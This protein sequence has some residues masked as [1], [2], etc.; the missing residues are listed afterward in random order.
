MADIELTNAAIP[1]AGPDQSPMQSSQ[2][3]SLFTSAPTS[4]TPPPRVVVG[5]MPTNAPNAQVEELQNTALP[6]RAVEQYLWEIKHQPNWRRASDTCAD[7]YD[8]NQLTLELVEKLKDRGQPPLITNLIKPTVDTVLGMEA[9]TRTDWIVRPED[10]TDS[11]DDVAEALSLKLKHAEIESRADRACSDAYAGQIKAGLGWV[12]VARESDPLKFPYRVSF[13]HR[14]EIFWDWRAEKYDLCDARYLVRRRWLELD[15]AIAM[16]P[17]YADL[18]RMTTSGWAGFDPLLEQNTHL[19]Q[20]FQLER[21]TRI[22][23]VDWRDIQRERVCLYEIWY[24]KWVRG[25]VVTLPNGK[26]V[27]CDF[28]NTEHCQAIMNGAPVKMATFQKVRLAWYCGPHFLYDI[29]SPYTHNYFPYVPFFGYREDLTQVP[30]GL[31]RSMISPQ[32]E[33]NARK[34]KA[35][36]LLNSRRVIADDDAVED[37]DRTM[38]EVARADAYIILNGRRKPGS[39]FEVEDGAQLSAQQLQAMQESKSEIEE[40]SGVH[41]VMQGQSGSASSGLAINSLV[42]QG[43]NTLAEINDNYRHARRLVGEQLFMLLQADMKGKQIGVKVGDGLQQRV[44]VLNQ[45]VQDPA[46]GQITLQNDISGIS[47]KVTMDDIP[48]TPTF[49]LQQ[50]QMLTEITKSLPPQLQAQVIDFVVAATDLPNRQEIV[51]RLRSS[52]G[53]LTPEQQQQKQQAQE[54][55]QQAQQQT[56]QKMEVLQAAKIASEVRENNAQA[57]YLEQ[58]AHVQHAQT[59]LTPGAPLGTPPLPASYP[60]T[61]MAAAPAAPAPAA[62]PTPP[63]AP[64]PTMTYQTPQPGAQP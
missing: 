9:K 4:T 31:I 44:I 25:Y 8:G 10:D 64:G 34:S 63:A 52:L 45:Q 41:K 17:Q 37:H 24:R 13:V 11:N 19:Y 58:Q 59:V 36:W 26:T 43:L 21:D 29:P 49:R 5:E 48:S 33:I 54:Q 51:D 56:A 62:P 32:D 12:E 46:T 16:M 20:S 47:P 60:A 53:I 57:S 35:L 15:H 7:Y 40:A 55:A 30:Y 3:A 22:E 14:R 50:L 28:D 27:E 61:P 2:M 18:F 39:K 42:E 38:E 1:I 6:Q 23:A